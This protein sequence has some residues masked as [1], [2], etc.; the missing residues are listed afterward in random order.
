MHHERIRAATALTVRYSIGGAV[1]S[2]FAI[3][4]R[5]RQCEHII[6]EFARHTLPALLCQRS[7][8]DQREA[9][10]RQDAVRQPEPTTT[11]RRV[12]PTT[13]NKSE[14][15]FAQRFRQK[16]TELLEQPRNK[17]GQNVIVGA[18]PFRDAPSCTPDYRPSCGRVRPRTTRRPRTCR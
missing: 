15:D 12:G 5:P 4:W 6:I 7:R 8:K 17:T 1:F 13:E 9:E 18:H 2:G 3:R 16:R 11:H 14:I 10:S